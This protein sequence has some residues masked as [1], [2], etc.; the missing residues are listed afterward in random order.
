[1]CFSL[2]FSRNNRD[3][4]KSQHRYNNLIL[5]YFALL[6]FALHKRTVLFSFFFKQNIVKEWQ[7]KY[8]TLSDMVVP[9]SS[10]LITE[11][12]DQMLFSVTLFKKVI[13]EYKT[14]CRENK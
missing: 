8:E 10:R 3:L 2:V 14:H 5:I 12:G 7:Q 13:D 1:M 11:D 9:G 4:S 6:Y